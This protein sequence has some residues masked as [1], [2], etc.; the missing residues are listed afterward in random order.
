MKR[1]LY[2][3]LIILLVSSAI[4]SQA[5][6]ASDKVRTGTRYKNTLAVFRELE[7]FPRANNDSVAYRL[8]VTA[9]FYHP[10][11]IR[12]EKTGARHVLHAK[13]LSGKVGYDWGKFKGEKTVNLTL[14]QWRTLNRLLDRASFCLRRLRPIHFVLCGAGVPLFNWRALTDVTAKDH[15]ACFCRCTWPSGSTL[16]SCAPVSVV[17]RARTDTLGC[18][19]FCYASLF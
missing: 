2:S 10:V 5:D 14:K 12:I 6:E 1:G 3:I 4:P 15:H 11:I 17:A 16:R 13:W 7:I 9:T 19:L 8:L 18:R